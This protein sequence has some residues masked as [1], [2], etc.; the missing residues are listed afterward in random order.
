MAKFIV[1]KEVFHGLG[2]LENLKEL[3]GKKAVIV[4]GGSS[5]KKNGS[6][7]RTQNYLTETILNQ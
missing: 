3:K 6:L 1:P 2:S 5:V 7:E 4:I